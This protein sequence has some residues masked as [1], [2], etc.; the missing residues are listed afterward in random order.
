MIRPWIPTELNL[1][2]QAFDLIEYR[3]VACKLHQLNPTWSEE[4]KQSYVRHAIREYEIHKKLDH[5]RIVRLLGIFE[6]D[7]N[8]FCTVLEYCDGGWR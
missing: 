8:T 4:K 1:V 3:H 7:N 5:P 6:I 2:S